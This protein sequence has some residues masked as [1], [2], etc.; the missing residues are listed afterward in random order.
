MVVLQNGMELGNGELDSPIGAGVTS[1]VEGND[2]IDV[3]AG[4]ITSITGVE[5]QEPSVPVT[6]TEHN[7]S[8]VP[9]MSVVHIA[10]RV[11]PEL[12]VNIGV[13]LWNKN[14]TLGS[15]FWKFSRT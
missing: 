13:C 15:R 12:A 4:G 6:Q 9:V 1:T 2:V 10:Y 3:E 11:C 7:V 8:C 14:L 5:N